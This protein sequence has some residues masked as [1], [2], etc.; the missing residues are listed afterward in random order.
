MEIFK[1]CVFWF[2]KQIETGFVS[3]YNELMNDETRRY[4]TEYQIFL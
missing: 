2:S 4:R 1:N 3:H